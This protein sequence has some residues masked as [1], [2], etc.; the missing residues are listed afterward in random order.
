MASE[1]LPLFPLNTVLFPGAQL[2]LRIFESRY[3][4]LVRECGRKGSGFGVC[5]I[6][7]G[8]EVGA[9]AQPAAIGCEARISDFS[10]GS[11]GLLH[12]SVQG[13]RRFRVERS[14]VRDN[15]Q[16]HGEVSWLPPPAAQALQTEHQLLAVLLQRILERAGP[17][18]DQADKAQ[19][20]DA[21]WVSW[22]LAE[23]LPL[24]G[25]EKQ[26]L[27]QTDSAFDRL[28]LLLRAVARLQEP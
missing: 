26:E 17:P 2:N 3:L 22:R 19:F 16:V 10:T 25:E 13:E 18:H 1:A 8:S 21:D 12:L 14:R 15:G 23:W 7:E 20:E 28:E 4:D 27:L 6:L 24:G 9:P 5:L 11:D